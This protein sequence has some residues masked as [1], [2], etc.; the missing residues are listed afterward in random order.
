M[1]DTPLHSRIMVPLDGSVAAERALLTAFELARRSGA[2]LD[3]V[4]V[5]S[6]WT[7]PPPRDSDADAVVKGWFAEE[8]ERVRG[9]LA[10]A[11]KKVEG[12]DVE[13]RIHARRGP[14]LETL[15]EWSEEL[16]TDLVVMTTHGRGGFRRA[17]LGSVSD[18]LL[19]RAPWPLLLLPVEDDEEPGDAFPL[20]KIVVPVDGSERS[21]A[22]LDHA[23]RLAHLVEGT[24]S[25]VTVLP[26]PA[27]ADDTHVHYGLSPADS[28]GAI[29]EGL[30]TYVDGLAAGIR[31][32]GIPVKADA[33][34][35]HGPAD[36]ILAHAEENDAD[37]ILMATRG[38]GGVRR[39]ML[40]SV[41]DKVIRECRWPILVHRVPEDLDTR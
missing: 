20:Q 22:V 5:I 33:R 38:R 11:R 32:Q 28:T 39:L 23:I 26:R 21:E 13:V 31:D 40:G 8:E 15:L 37:L 1:T 29:L 18:G 6:P 41:A 16:G 17:W 4:G 2:V 24:L 14:V 3:L 25:L 12:S 35:A 27:P 36:G 7:I 9:Y 30:G 10:R 19:R 34:Q